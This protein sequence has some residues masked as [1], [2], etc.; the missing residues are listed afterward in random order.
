[1][2]THQWLEAIAIISFQADTCWCLW[3]QCVCVC[4]CVCGVH[5]ILNTKFVSA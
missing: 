2:L 1:M 4:V 3:G 5:W